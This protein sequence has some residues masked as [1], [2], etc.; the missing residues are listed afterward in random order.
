[1]IAAVQNVRQG[2]GI[3]ELGPVIAAYAVCIARC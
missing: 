2:S 3:M 1:M